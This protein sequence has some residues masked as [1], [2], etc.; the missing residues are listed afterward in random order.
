[1][2]F[3]AHHAVMFCPG[4]YCRMQRTW[5][6]YDGIIYQCDHCRL[7]MRYRSADGRMILV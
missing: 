2:M 3:S 7:K 4:Q 1:M 6:S 5:T